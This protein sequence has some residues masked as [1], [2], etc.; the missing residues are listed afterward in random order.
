M[1][2]LGRRFGLDSLLR[3]AECAHLRW[4]IPQHVRDAQ[5]RYV[6]DV[7]NLLVPEHA[8]IYLV[9][10]Y[11]QYLKCAKPTVYTVKQWPVAS[12]CG[13]HILRLF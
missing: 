9:P 4:V 5:V 10:T 2:Q 3:V 7:Y 12:E 1:R 11:R 6:C 13:G 8:M